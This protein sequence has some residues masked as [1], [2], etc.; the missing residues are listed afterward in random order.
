MRMFH[1]WGWR[2]ILDCS[3]SLL[4]LIASISVK[5]QPSLP[6]PAVI[7]CF[8]CDVYLPGWRGGGSGINSMW[9]WPSLT[10][11]GSRWWERL[12]WRASVKAS[13]YLGLPC[14]FFACCQTPNNSVH[15]AG[16][17]KCNWLTL[18]TPWL[19]ST[20]HKDIQ[21]VCLSVFSWFVYY[22]NQFVS[23]K[24]TCL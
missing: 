7:V 10:L 6:L 18:K 9:K 11:F 3:A 23:H 19:K 4:I 12:L 14:C 16:C 15:T 21:C 8:L 2:Q 22:A 1:K 20:N 5:A 13:C 24:V 17:G